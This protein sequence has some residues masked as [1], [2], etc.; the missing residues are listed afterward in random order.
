MDAYFDPDALD[1]QKVSM[2]AVVVAFLALMSLLGSPFQWIKRISSI[3]F[4]SLR[5]KRISGR[6]QS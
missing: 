4:P 2:P 5:L 3:A 6:T 1:R